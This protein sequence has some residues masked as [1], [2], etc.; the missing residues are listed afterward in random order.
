MPILDNPDELVFILL[1]LTVLS[2]SFWEKEQLGLLISLHFYRDE[3]IKVKVVLLVQRMKE[4]G[5]LS[6][7][8]KVGAWYFYRKNIT[9]WAGFLN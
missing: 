4:R 6:A 1:P 7:A 5:L 8:W 9:N 2:I 3:E